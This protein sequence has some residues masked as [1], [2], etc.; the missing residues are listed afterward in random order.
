MIVPMVQ[1]ELASS[2]ALVMS[3]YKSGIWIA[4]LSRTIVIHA[5]TA[6]D[7]QDGVDQVRRSGYHTKLRIWHS[8]VLSSHLLM[9]LTVDAQFCDQRVFQRTECRFSEFNSGGDEDNETQSAQAASKRYV[10]R[11]SRDDIFLTETMG[12]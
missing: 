7:R 8:S 12:V 10:C 3:L 4:S 2:A 6:Q 11:L 5:Y 1:Q 9:R